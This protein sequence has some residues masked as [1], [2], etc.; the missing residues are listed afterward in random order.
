[1]G[2]RGR[3]RTALDTVTRP[4]WTRPTWRAYR[5]LFAFPP[6]V[7]LV[8]GDA[9][10]RMLAANDLLDEGYEMVETENAAEAMGILRA[11]NDFDAVIADIDLDHAPGGLALVRHIARSH[12]DMGILIT[13]E[14]K[15][16]ESETIG[17]GFLAK[18]YADGALISEMRLLLS[19]AVDTAAVPIKVGMST[20]G[21]GVDI[22]RTSERVPV[23]QAG[24]EGKPVIP[25][26]RER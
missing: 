14:G 6:L 10:T 8:E 23:S 15:D 22:T 20:P 19:R 9:E 7:L 1:M 25:P 5:N 2:E 21:K 18:P 11:R 12:Q 26:L 3:G 4:T 16:G 24:V 17:S 13:S